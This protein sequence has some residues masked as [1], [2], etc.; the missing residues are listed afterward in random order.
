MTR[1][2]TFFPCV[3]DE[4]PARVASCADAL[5]LEFA[6]HF[7]LSLISPITANAIIFVDDRY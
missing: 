4:T 2:F 3:Y 1:G 5:H 6:A 7:D